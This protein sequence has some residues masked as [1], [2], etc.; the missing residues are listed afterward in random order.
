MD[1]YIVIKI[2]TA[3]ASFVLQRSYGNFGS[4]RST[5]GHF[6]V[7]ART[8][9]KYNTRWYYL[10]FLQNTIQVSYVLLRIGDFY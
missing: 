3:L 9:T 6:T 5:L 7:Q 4:L 10:H 1:K 8:F 2:I